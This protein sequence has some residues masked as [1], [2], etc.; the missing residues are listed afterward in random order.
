MKR[1][2]ILPVL[3]VSILV[4]TPTMALAQD[5]PVAILKKHDAAIAR[6]D[7]DAAI[8]LYADDAIQDGGGGCFRRPCV[9]K[10][11]IR[12]FWERIVKGKPR[13]TIIAEYPSGNVSTRRIEIRDER[14]SKA[15]V[16]RFVVWQIWG[17]KG[18]KISFLRLS[19][20]RS[21]PQTVR[22][23]K[24]EREQR[25]KKANPVSWTLST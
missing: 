14:T 16:D 22:F 13:L 11:A 17:I 21:D 15:G 2:M 9:G 8:A 25:K 20:E 19:P 24:F 6:G 10:A 12:K 7:V 18:G 23:L 5:D 3:L 1:F 4:V